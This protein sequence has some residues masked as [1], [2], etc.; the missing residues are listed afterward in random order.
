MYSLLLFRSYHTFALT[1]VK[2]AEWAN[3]ATV[4]I[5]ERKFGALFGALWLISAKCLIAPS[6][7]S[8]AE[9]SSSFVAG[10]G[11]GVDVEARNTNQC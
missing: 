7:P 6:L 1:G 10:N 2:H 4:I 11:D 5:G 9:H 8:N 3:S